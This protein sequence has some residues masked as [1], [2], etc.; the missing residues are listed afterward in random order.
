MTRLGLQRLGTVMKP[1][2]DD[3]R[4][5]EGVLN[6]AAAHGPGGQLYLFPR[7]VGHGNY[8][9]IGLARVIFDE[10]GDPSGVERM[11]TAPEPEADYERRRDG[12]G[13]CEDPRVTLVE[14]L[15][16]YL[17]S[18]TAFSA[19]PLRRLLRDGRRP[20]RRSPPRPARRAAPRR[21]PRARTRIV[22]L[23]A[24]R[25]PHA[26]TARSPIRAHH[27]AVAR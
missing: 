5:V 26:M 23:A 14:P 7:L 22:F 3:P 16:R 9:R 21:L 4:E 10:A 13:G 12:S 24:W 2:P 17:M 18:Y 8:S 19:R 11:G 1:D 27:T 6:P 20:H 15:G 25:G